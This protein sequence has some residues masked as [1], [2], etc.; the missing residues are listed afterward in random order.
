MKIMIEDIQPDEEEEIIIRCRE[1]DEELLKIIRHLKQGNSKL[2]LYQNGDVYL[3]KPEEVYYFESV[4]QKVF[5]YL[6]SEVYEI[7]SKLYELEEELPKK[8]FFRA[9]KSTIINVNKIKSL[10]PAFSGRLEA[11]LL[12]GEK[13]IISR[14]Y[15]ADLKE[16][17]G[18]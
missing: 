16:R 2:N 1:M 11:L 15:V 10:T 12:N 6:K 17:L 4:D 14:Q 9:T 7:K 13:M 3:T 5:A 8:D 18:L